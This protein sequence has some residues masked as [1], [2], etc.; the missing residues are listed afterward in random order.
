MRAALII[1][2]RVETRRGNSFGRVTYLT[3]GL[4]TA[5]A[6]L[7]ATRIYFVS[8]LLVL[9]AALAAMFVVGTGVMLFIVLVQAGVHWS[10]RQIIQA[11]QRTLFLRGGPSFQSSNVD[12]E[13]GVLTTQNVTNS[14]RK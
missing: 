9:W 10:V 14:L 1:R 13:H 5:V 4:P 12:R 8:E 6:I 7:L 11:K 2:D 3:V